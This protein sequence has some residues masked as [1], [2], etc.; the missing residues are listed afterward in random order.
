[1]ALELWAVLELN[2]VVKVVTVAGDYLE[3]QL[4]I[5]KETGL[6]LYLAQQIHE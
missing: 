5:I 6:E 4:G 3:A 1:M 2:D